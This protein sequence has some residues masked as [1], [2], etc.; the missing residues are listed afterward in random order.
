MDSEMGESNRLANEDEPGK[1]DMPDDEDDDF[2]QSNTYNS[3]EQRIFFLVVRSS[4]S[5]LFNKLNPNFL[6]VFVFI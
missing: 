2:V 6:K 1:F 4:R 5:R 3:F